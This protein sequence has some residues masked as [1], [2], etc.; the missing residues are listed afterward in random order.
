M[1]VLLFLILIFLVRGWMR[2][3]VLPGL[4]GAFVLPG[5]TSVEQNE[6]EK[7]RSLLPPLSGTVNSQHGCDLDWAKHL[8]ASVNCFATSE[9]EVNSSE[10]KHVDISADSLSAVPSELKRYGW[11]SSMPSS[12]G[13]SRQDTFEV[14]FE[15]NAGKHIVCTFNYSAYKLGSTQPGFD[16]TTFVLTCSRDPTLLLIAD[17]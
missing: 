2:S 1:I 11:R 8:T 15:R 16:H 9:Q 12:D 5:L 6:S 7:I 10:L 14:S 3:T 4:T 17:K 13:T